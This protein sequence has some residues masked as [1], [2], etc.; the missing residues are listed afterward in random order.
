M[1]EDQLATWGNDTPLCLKKMLVRMFQRLLFRKG[2]GIW[3]LDNDRL[4]Y[5]RGNWIIPF[6][7]FES[8]DK[9]LKWGKNSFLSLY[10]YLSLCI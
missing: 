7:A 5:Q 6:P 3:R 10:C 4:L 8:N 9:R 1:S 2:Y